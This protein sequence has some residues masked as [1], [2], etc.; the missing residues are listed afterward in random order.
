[1]GDKRSVWHNYQG[2]RRD[3]MLY[4]DGHIDYSRLPQTMD[5]TQPV[6]PNFTWW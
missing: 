6:D 3:N 2:Q 4:G 1:M 5:V